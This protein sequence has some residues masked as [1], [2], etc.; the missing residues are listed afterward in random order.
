MK[1]TYPIGMDCKLNSDG[2]KIICTGDVMARDLYI[3]GKAKVYRI[4]LH[5]CP[6]ELYGEN[7][8]NEC[9]C[10][11]GESCHQISGFCKN[12]CEDGW[13]GEKCDKKTYVNIAQGKR[14][15][16]AGYGKNAY[17]F[18]NGS[19]KT[20]ELQMTSDK[21][22]DGNFDPAFL[23]KSCAQTKIGTELHWQVTF[24]EPYV[25][26]QLRIY[27]R[28]KD[29][30]RLRGF[31]VY[32]G[33]SLC[34]ESR[35]HEHNEQV[36]HVKCEKPVS[37]S[38]VKIS[39]EGSERQLTLCEV[40][41]LQC[42]HGFYGDMCMERCELCV[43][44]KC[45]Q[46][47]GCEQ[48]CVSGYYWDNFFR[49]CKECVPGFYG[50]MC[51]ERCEL[52][53]GSK[54]DQVTGHC[55]EGCITGY[56][57]DNTSKRC[58]EKTENNLVS[59]IVP[60]ILLIVLIM[61]MAVAIW[62]C[63]KK[64]PVVKR[65]VRMRKVSGNIY[66]EGI[67]GDTAHLSGEISLD[68]RESICIILSSSSFKQN[69]LKYVAHK[70]QE[71]EP[72]NKEFQRLPKL[73]PMPYNE[74]MKPENAKKNQYKT[75]LPYD[76]SRVKLQPDEISSSDYINAN[77]I[78]NQRYIA[79]QGATQSTVTD[80]WRMIWQLKCNIIVLLEDMNAAGKVRF[81]K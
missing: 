17:V 62:Y 10:S 42:V 15:N 81:K 50:D 43:D 58:K 18:D 3:N 20:T 2:N 47:T 23:H 35:H 74:A 28:M 13:H 76:H 38:N 16:Q 45:D 68:E 4:T 44:S 11:R 71:A 31:K 40:E 53:V 30:L 66:S 48:G 7:C 60:L 46:V 59:M 1:I 9:H 69:L 39:L 36:I 41:V 29:R 79:C 73:L 75:I 6:P 5:G 12:G 34:F 72:F 27:N 25:I 22:V 26:S 24:D 56:D 67:S 78:C 55:E 51:M 61:V 33:S 57:W 80:F 52:C 63:R 21:A 64:R 14:T 77:F 54:C 8:T 37:S 49:K 70:K 65:D 32:L 19:C